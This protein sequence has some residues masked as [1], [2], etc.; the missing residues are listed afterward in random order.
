[1]AAAAAGSDS[2]AGGET[3]AAFTAAPPALPARTGRRLLSPSSSALALIA[4]IGEAP[5]S[6]S[7]DVASFGTPAAAA[8]RPSASPPAPAEATPATAAS[9]MYVPSGGGGGSGGGS[10]PDY[11]GE[12]SLI[13]INKNGWRQELIFTLDRKTVG[14][15][16][17]RQQAAQ[18]FGF[19]GGTRV[20]VRLI[21]DLVRVEVSST[22]PRRFAI[23]FRE[24]GSGYVTQQYETSSSAEREELLRAL[25]RILALKFNDGKVIVAP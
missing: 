5:S 7:E 16:K 23:V 11:G 3:S 6:P 4:G 1:V 2:G 20:A 10:L 17:P 21:E 12:W 14:N 15:L 8:P 13:K 18:M 9:T 25:I 24:E 22:A 19:S